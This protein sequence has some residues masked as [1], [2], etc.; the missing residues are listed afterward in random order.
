MPI[1]GQHTTGSKADIFTPVNPLAG[2]SE[3]QQSVQEAM[4]ENVDKRMKSALND[5]KKKYENGG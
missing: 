4:Q 3:E 1:S 5:L 2:M